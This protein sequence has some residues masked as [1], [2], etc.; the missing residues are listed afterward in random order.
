MR[1]FAA[2]L[3]VLAGPAAAQEAPPLLKPA[4]AA[5]IAGE[6]SGSAAKRIVQALSL[7]HRMRGSEG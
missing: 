7:H 3:L 4:E 5:A 2:L 6:V 1:G